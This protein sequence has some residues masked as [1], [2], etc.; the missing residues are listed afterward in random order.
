MR[1]MT[2]NRLID[3]VKIEELLKITTLTPIMSIIKSKVLKLFEHIKRSKSGLLKFVW[4]VWS[5]AKEIE[6]DNRNVGVTI[7]ILGLNLIL[8]TSMPRPRIA[9]FGK[10][11][12]MLVHNLPLVEIVN[13]DED[14][15]CIFSK[16]I[17][18]HQNY[19][20]H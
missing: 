13:H 14:E 15:T 6:E 11:Y 8:L 1:F 5:R 4:K 16:H 17:Q 18:F 12:T 9:I 2:N 7:A 10:C 19:Y 3:H 20:P